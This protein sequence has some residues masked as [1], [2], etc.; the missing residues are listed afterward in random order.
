MSC[1]NNI[2]VD[3][4][5]I[6]FLGVTAISIVTWSCGNGGLVRASATASQS[7][8]LERMGRSGKGALEA[9]VGSR[10]HDAQCTYPQYR[11]VHRHTRRKRE[12]VGRGEESRSHRTAACAGEC[13]KVCRDACPKQCPTFSLTNL[14]KQLDSDSRHVVN[15]IMNHIFKLLML[16]C[17]C[18]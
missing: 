8:E 9:T 7:I 4:D 11:T 5:G 14:S 2:A 12:K 6:V 1:E 16:I 3:V 10:E 17:I 15:I 18:D 13:E